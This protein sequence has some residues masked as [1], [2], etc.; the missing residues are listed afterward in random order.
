MYDLVFDPVRIIP[1]QVGFG[2][3]DLRRSLRQREDQA[4]R[5]KSC[6]GKNA[7]ERL[8]PRP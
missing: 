7:H 1:A 6:A 2:L 3:V 8:S 5:A 4:R